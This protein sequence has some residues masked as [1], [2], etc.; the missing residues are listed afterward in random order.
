MIGNEYNIDW[1]AC[2]DVE[3]VPGRCSGQWV[4][5]DSRILVSGI[6]ENYDAGATPEEIGE[7]IYDGLGVARARRILE[8]AESHIR[9]PLPHA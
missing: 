1:T 4:V 2:A 5:K 8:Y 7:E 6:I 3:R 9:H